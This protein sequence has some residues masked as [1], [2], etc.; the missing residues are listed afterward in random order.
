MKKITDD[1]I[2]QIVKQ[3][4]PAQGYKIVTDT[5]HRGFGL[6]IIARSEKNPRWRRFIRV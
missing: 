3:Y 5:T 4:Q 1:S 2:K 6:R